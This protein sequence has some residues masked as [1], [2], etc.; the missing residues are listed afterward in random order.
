MPRILT[1]TLAFLTLPAL[2][3]GPPPPAPPT[4]PMQFHDEASSATRNR[5][6]AALQTQLDTARAQLAGL[7]TSY[8]ESSPKVV[9]ARA[10]IKQMESDLAREQSNDRPRIMQLRMP[11]AEQGSDLGIVPPGTWWRYP[12][13]IRDLALTPDQ[14][15]K[16]DEIFRQNRIQ[17]IDLKASLEKE[18]LNLEPI[19]N[20]NP[21]DTT[22]AFSEIS[23]IADLRADLEKANAKM[24]L[25]LRSQLTADQWTRLQTQRPGVYTSAD[26]GIN[27]LRRNNETSNNSTTTTCTQKPGEADGK[28]LCTTTTVTVNMKD[29]TGKRTIT[30]CVQAPGQSAPRCT[31]TPVGLSEG[32]FKIFMPNDFSA[33]HPLSFNMGL[34]FGDAPE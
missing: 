30:T 10:S 25:G 34:P 12:E 23:R 24:L 7:L 28:K 29:T 16:M 13:T 3:Q 31:T 6:T 15:H 20:G 8:G 21:P 9:A 22:K 33:P 32:N 19:L 27:W 2:A 18:Q 5:H 1:L 26:G 11:R 17:L 14:Q 4:P